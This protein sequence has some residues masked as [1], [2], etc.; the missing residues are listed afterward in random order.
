MGV[1][2]VSQGSELGAGA[3]GMGEE[4]WLGA[5]THISSVLPQKQGLC[6]PL[7][8]HPVG[9]QPLCFCSCHDLPRRLV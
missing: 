7:S 3:A 6:C 5:R 4:P 8:A 1:G 2:E 9:V